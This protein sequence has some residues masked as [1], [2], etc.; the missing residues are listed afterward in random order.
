MN[1][2]TDRLTKTSAGSNTNLD[3]K[4]AIPSHVKL[5]AYCFFNFSTN[6]ITYYPCCVMYHK[7]WEKRG[8]DGRNEEVTLGAKGKKSKWALL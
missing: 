8:P 4:T 3:P 6:F 5:L 2:Y 1:R 7:E